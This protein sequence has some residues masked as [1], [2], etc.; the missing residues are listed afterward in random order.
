[1]TVSVGQNTVNPPSMLSWNVLSA[2]E[3]ISKSAKALQPCLDRIVVKFRSLGPAVGASAS[4]D[5]KT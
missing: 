3:D 5:V 4:A 1:M 2:P